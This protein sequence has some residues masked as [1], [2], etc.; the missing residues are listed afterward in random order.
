[1]AFSYFKQ[2][3]L[4]SVV[5]ALCTL[6]LKWV[7][8]SLT[9]S[10]G[11]LSDALES[12]IN[13]AAALT[14][15]FSIWFSSRP[16]DPSHTYGHEKIEYF[17]SGLEG[18]LIL[19][20]AGGIAWYAVLRILTPQKLEA[21][22]IGMVLALVASMINLVVAQILL[23][24][25]RR[26]HSIVL[27]ADGK[28]LMTDVI[29]SAAVILGV[30]LAWFT[31]ASWLDP[32]VALAVAASIAWMGWDLVRRSF[33]GLMDHAL[34]TEEQALVRGAIAGRLLTGMDFHA[35]RTRRAGSRRF[36][37][38]HLLVPGAWSVRRAHEV[39]AGI[40]A[41][42]AAAFPEIEITAHIEPIE[43]KAAWEDSA[44][45]PIEQAARRAEE[46]AASERTSSE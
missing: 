10:I 3:I 18:A 8:Y 11:L 24:S 1:M 43:D 33:N 38:F 15:Y 6:G 21:F 4:L 16:V 40:E 19:A 7:A 44:L 42:I 34:P 26:T 29:T 20:A 22:E 32:V 25:A 37:D 30:G 35:L 36:V 27:E 2:P 28:H 12:L 45:L 5:A 14:A 39:L 41:A 46:E 9:G 13:L 17:S 23:R 31:D